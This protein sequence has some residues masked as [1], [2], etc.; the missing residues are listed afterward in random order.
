MSSVHR[1]RELRLFLIFLLSLTAL[2]GFTQD[3]LQP[4][5]NVGCP[6]DVLR[7]QFAVNSSFVLKVVFRDKPMPAVPIVLSRFL[8]SPDNAT[9]HVGSVRVAQNKTDA[10][11]KLEFS[12]LEPGD[13]TLQI[14]D[15]LAP[16]SVSLIVSRLE[17]QHEVKVEW[18]VM[19]YPFELYTV[20]NLHGNLVSAGAHK[21]FK[22]VLVEL[23][24][25]HTSRLLAHAR[26]DSSGHYELDWWSNGVYVLRF[27]PSDEFHHHVDLGVALSNTSETQ[28]LPLMTVDSSDCGIAIW[29]TLREVSS[30]ICHLVVH[31]SPCSNQSQLEIGKQMA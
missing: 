7:S 6:I 15:V 24:D 20:S 8:R 2:P 9:R 1:T 16:Q 30:L 29:P 14:G 23:F 4:S 31:K 3:K 11:G 18:P 17:K 26:T 25:A 12:G 27:T 22:D 28:Y 10:S 13:Y 19:H 21:P 5:P